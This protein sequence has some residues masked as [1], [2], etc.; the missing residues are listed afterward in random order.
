ML[1]PYIYHTLSSFRTAFSRERSFTLFSLVIIAF[2]AS[3][4]IDGVSSFC[5]FWM[6]DSSGYHA[7]LH[8]F[9]SQ[10]YQLSGLV[11]CWGDFVLKQNLHLQLGGFNILLGDHIYIP[12]DGRRM[13]G[14]CTHHQDSETQTKPAYFRGHRFSAIGLLIGTKLLPFC[15]PLALRIHQGFKHIGQ[16]DEK[17]DEKKTLAPRMIEMA[18]SWCKE[19]KTPSLLVLDAFFSVASTF[20]AAGT[21]LF[22]LTRAKKNYVAYHLAQQ[23]LEKK[24]GAPRKYGEKVHLYEVF[25]DLQEVSLGEA[26]VYGKKEEVA[27]HA[28]NL[29]W[30][31]TG[32][33]LRFIFVCTSHGSMVLMSN[34]LEL[35]PIVAI[36]AYCLRIRIE[37]MFD[38]LKNLLGTFYYRFWSKHLPRHSRKPK[39]N[40]ELKSPPDERVHKV[41]AT[42]ECYERFVMFGAISLG[43]LQ[44][45]SLKYTQMIWSSFQGFLRTRSRSIPSER[46]VKEVVGQ[47]LTK[48]FFDV[49]CDGRMRELKEVCDEHW[50]NPK[51][52]FREAA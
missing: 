12:K 2:L 30:R 23:L 8:F 41:K 25:D 49:A 39:K 36:E 37:T 21:A 13:P 47:E 33:M 31:P 45:L 20:R 5:R 44:I 26:I 10:S 34:H 40:S 14:V 1:L 18:V 7:L 29:L 22:V 43:I 4:R 6:L 19:H 48:N 38:K 50:R 16:K 32:G 28:M 9:H 27:Y 51:N 15:I 3:Y 46:T 52:E 42:W 35:H 17:K 24:R 11:T